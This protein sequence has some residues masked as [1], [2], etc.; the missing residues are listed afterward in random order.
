MFFSGEQKKSTT[1]L[2]LPC[3]DESPF[4]LPKK[5]IGLHHQETP[6][7]D[8]S[9][10][11]AGFHVTLKRG[12]QVKTC[13]CLNG[14]D[15]DG[16]GIQRAVNAAVW[17]HGRAGDMCAQSLGENGV[18]ASDVIEAIPSVMRELESGRKE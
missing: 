15:T 13:E 7:P 6:V 8:A 3:P 14:V 11:E 4:L 17:I 5:I 18:L 9:L 10:L 12:K 2:T 1:F 16:I